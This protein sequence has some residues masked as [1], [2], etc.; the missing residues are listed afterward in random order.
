MRTKVVVESDYVRGEMRGR[1]TA[2]ETVEF[3]REVAAAALKNKRTRILIVVRESRAIF[4]VE[5]F[6]L[7][8][9]FKAMVERPG[10]RIAMVGDSSESHAAHGYIEVLARQRKLAVRAFREE[11]PALEWLRRDD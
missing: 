1:D 3:L 6:S 10:Y 5:E 4:K 2:A 11:N 9:Y 7:S 8:E